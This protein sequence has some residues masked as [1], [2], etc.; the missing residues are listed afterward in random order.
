MF[1]FALRNSRAALAAALTLAG[2]VAIFAAS[3]DPA[4]A[5]CKYGGPNCV[6]PRPGV[7][8]PKVNDTKIPDSGWV[9]ADCKYY[10]NCLSPNSARRTP[11]GKVQLIVKPKAT[12]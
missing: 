9:D 3:A 2:A 11:G 5:L 6:N 8:G 4:S 12:R 7:E 1:T 10:G